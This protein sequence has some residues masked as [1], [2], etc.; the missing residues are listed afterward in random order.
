MHRDISFKKIEK[1]SEIVV[2][3]AAGIAGVPPHR[4]LA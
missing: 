2:A 4:L 3:V 1:T